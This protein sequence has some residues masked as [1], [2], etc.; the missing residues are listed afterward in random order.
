MSEGS[1]IRQFLGGLGFD[2]V[3]QPLVLPVDKVIGVEKKSFSSNS[4]NSKHSKYQKDVELRGTS[5][6]GWPNYE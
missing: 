2:E 4:S 6:L 3:L 1:H 5:T